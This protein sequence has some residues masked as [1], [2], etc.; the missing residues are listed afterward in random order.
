M[1]NSA[2]FSGFD[3]TDRQK[4]IKCLGVKFKKCNTNETIMS[5]NDKREY[6]Y[7]LLHGTAE[8]AS[9]D[10]D[11]NK[12][13]LERF[14]KDSVF[15]ELF[16]HSSGTDEVIVTALEECEVLLFKYNNAISQCAKACK[17]H[18]KFIDNLFM[19]ISKKLIY[20]SQHIEVLSKRTI[21]EKLLAFFEI[22]AK[23]NGSF[24]F[25][26]PF[27]LSSLADFLSVDRSAMQREIKRLNDEGL[28]VSKGRKIT[29]IKK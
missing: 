14:S 1:Q 20:Q 4:M 16:F 5:Y 11:G 12:S 8:L 21:R 17:F 28:L 24:F 6:I 29:L 23:E 19:M 9:Y 27:S 15:G 3:A 10:Y 22:Q 13:I 7:V 25:S 2:L 26:L 18:A